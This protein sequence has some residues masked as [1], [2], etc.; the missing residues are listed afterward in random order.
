[1]EKTPTPFNISI[2][3]YDVIAVMRR[4]YLSL[5]ADQVFSYVFTAID[6][7]GFA[8]VALW[9]DEERVSSLNEAGSWR[10]FKDPET[11]I[12]FMIN[13]SGVNINVAGA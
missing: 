13:E 11:A 1:M 7:K 6:S 2:E 9:C 12:A 10:S 8:V 5:N 3:G 4:A